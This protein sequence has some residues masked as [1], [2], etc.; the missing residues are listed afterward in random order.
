MPHRLT[1]F[2]LLAICSAALPGGVSANE[3]Y[4]NQFN[5]SNY[6]NLS[7]EL[8]YLRKTSPGE[9]QDK[10]LDYLLARTLE[11]RGDFA[12]AMASYQNVVVQNGILK[13]FALKHLSRLLRESGNY[14]LERLFLNELIFAGDSGTP[15]RI[16]RSRLVLSH[17]ESSDFGETI[18]MIENGIPTGPAY[19]FDFGGNDREL[20]VVLGKSYLR[21]AK[22]EKAREVFNGLIDSVPD[23]AQPDDFAL[24]AVKGLDL[25]ETGESGFDNEVKNLV[26]TEQMKRGDIYQFNRSFGRARLHYLSM[27]ENHIGNS[28][29]PAAMAKIARGYDQERDYKNALVWNERLLSEFPKDKLAPA[30]LYSTAGSHAASGNNKEAV[31]RYERF[32]SENPDADN[33]ERA[34]LNIVDAFRD[35][36]DISKALEW[37]G[38]ARQVFAG[39]AGETSALFA[40]SRI[41]IAAEDWQRALETLTGLEKKDLKPNIAG[42]TNISEVKFLKGFVFEQLK[43]FP[44]AI[45]MFLSIEDGRGEYYGYR[46]TE[47]LRALTKNPQAKA[48]I[49]QK[50]VGLRSR[51]GIL[52]AEGAKPLLS[53]LERLEPGAAL[54][55]LAASYNSTPAYTPPEF[56]AET[57][58]FQTKTARLFFEFGLFDEAAPEIE[59]ELRKRANSDG[60]VSNGN[61]APILATAYAQGGF[62]ERGIAFIEPK[63]K[64]LPR[65]FRVELIPKDQAYLLYPAPYRDSLL[66]HGKKYG[67]DPRLLLAVM[68]QESR[69]QSDIKSAAA[70]RGLMQFVSGTARKMADEMN[71]KDFRQDDLYDPDSA[72]RFGAHYISNIYKDFPGKPE[73]VAASYNGGEDRMAR[74]LKRSKTNDPDRFVAEIVFSQTKDYVYKVMSNY[75]MYRLLYDESLIRRNVERI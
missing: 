73:A 46:A 74:W 53:E 8:V 64:K 6:E 72:I 7:R 44:E 54:E 15:G 27:V 10:N 52:S 69:F 4:A 40:E 20:S 9:F 59:I 26:A 29:V 16:A 28:D 36:N 2:L 42:G 70:A 56:T 63:W 49:E 14:P 61:L 21:T 41:F 58:E 33:P 11:K 38:K 32:I 17:F 23:S 37:T 65:D 12:G 60:T 66:K 48:A 57:P 31:K 71:L 67:V 75:R 24:E 25:L 51:A 13:P 68:R 18:D 39:K 22:A 45:D 47:R 34:Y 5:A 55:D 30:A 35:E 62:A 19:N 3:P 43:R 50:I 1:V